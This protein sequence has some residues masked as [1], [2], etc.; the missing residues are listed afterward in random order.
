MAKTKQQPK[1][2][3]ISNHKPSKTDNNREKRGKTLPPQR[4]DP[5]DSNIPVV[6]A[7]KKY[8]PP[9]KNPVF[10]KNWNALI[11]DVSSRDNFTPA[12]LNQLEVLCGLYAEYDDLQKFIR[13]HGYTYDAFGRHGKMIR[14][15]PQVTRIKTIETSIAMYSK[16][17]GLL[18]KKSEGGGPK[19]GGDEDGWE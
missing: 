14:T 11:K 2:I 19:G 1:K 15:Y 9:K 13:I 12:H 4:P 18:L 16:M 10:Q 3:L 17:L 7:M 5:E 6:A 8:P